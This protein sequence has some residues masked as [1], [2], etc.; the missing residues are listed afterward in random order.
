M[1][2]ILL[3]TICMLLTACGSDSETQKPLPPNEGTPISP[4]CTVDCGDGGDKNPGGGESPI[5]PAPLPPVEGTPITPICTVDCG[6]GGDK[7]PGGGDKPL[8]DPI[9]VP[10]TEIIGT[11]NNYDSDRSAIAVLAS[12]DGEE[13]LATSTIGPDGEFQFTGLN[14][15]QEYIVSVSQSG[16]RF[17]HENG[18]LTFSESNLQTGSSTIISTGKHITFNGDVIDGLEQDKFTYYWSEDVSVSGE[19]HSSYI[20][21]PLPI[22]IIGPDFSD[23]DSHASINLVKMFG[24]S[25]QDTDVNWTP[26]HAYRLLESLLRTGLEDLPSL[27]Q[28]D[29]TR[30]FESHWELTDDYIHNDIE[31]IKREG[32]PPLVRIDKA[33]FTYASPMVATVDGKKGRFFSNRLFKAGVRFLTDNGNDIV[34]AADIIKRRYGIKIATDEYFE[35]LYETVPVIDEDRS[36]G[37]WQMFQPS[38]LIEIIAMF[39]EFPSGMQDISFPNDDGGLR[40]LLRRRNGLLHPLYEQAAAVAWTSANYIEYME[41]AFDQ[42]AVADVQR[43]IIHEKAH[44]M[45]DFVFSTELK[46]E[47]LKQS[48]WYMPGDGDADCAGWAEDRHKWT[49]H[50]VD[51][52]TLEEK[53][54]THDHQPLQGEPVIE[55]AWASCSTT[56]FVTAYAAKL[57]PNED[58]AESLAFFLTNPDMLRSRSLPKYEFIRDYI[59]QGTIYLSVIRPDLTFE[60]LNLYPDYIY[61]GKINEVSITVD[62]GPSDDKQVKV[63]LGL[64]VNEDCGDVDDKYCFDGAA[65]A[66]MRLISPIGTYRDQY[67]SP[68]NGSVDSELYA[69]F[70]LP[71]MA[72]SGWW[73]PA[74]IV[75]T[76]QVGNRRIE[77]F[78]SSDYGWRL[79]VN[80]PDADYTPPEY[81]ANSMNLK[82][83]NHESENIP[84]EIADDEQILQM[85]WLI[86]EDRSMEDGN[87]FTRVANIDADREWG[88]YSNDLYTYDVPRVDV[89]GA[90][91]LCE[92]NWLVTRFIAPGEYS[93]AYVNMKDSAFN[94]GRADFSFDHPTYESPVSL[95]LGGSTPDVEAP[96]VDAQACA[97]DDL[98]ERCL[99]IVGEPLNPENPN[100]ETRVRI[101]YWAYEDQPL[102]HASGLAISGIRLRNPQGQEFHYWHGDSS[103]GL[104][105]YTPNKNARYFTCHEHAQETMEE[106]DA[107][108]PIQYIFETILP[109]GSAPGTWGLTELNVEDFAGNKNNYGFTENLRF[110][111][112]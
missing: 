40:Y 7:N 56:E 17:K 94:H 4:P 110:E 61:P 102:S 20:N 87:C 106:C 63:K 43:L 58:M 45:W 108:T 1:K 11:L 53:T 109:V 60:V 46:Y 111:V 2:K 89:P 99:R 70:T 18:D 75:V 55:K 38:E 42:G 5:L 86:N 54:E 16:Y 105:G 93:P 76:D 36:A 50:N 100:G 44:F 22:E 67:F 39:E 78:S 12:A 6:D 65:K 48:G 98:E 91:H 101:Y 41:S 10:D 3:I 85:S 59:M 92:I 8:T 27:S 29:N 71:S 77:K 104:A 57:N 33:S 73:T 97:T 9:F 30:R 80:N 52:I 26:E 69:E 23:V 79:Y 64:H 13:L 35:G 74:E 62:G 32:M 83:Y 88:L 95:W 49:P 15:D 19:E 66:Y 21:E 47:W 68:V 96:I 37:I 34:L 51:P 103:S 81:V 24:I 25:L 82:L 28:E 107:T 72:A 112:D 14:K 31:I 84:F 90:T